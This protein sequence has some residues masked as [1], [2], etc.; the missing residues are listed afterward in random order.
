MSKSRFFIK[1]KKGFTL[2]ELLVVIAIMAVAA[3]IV[4]PNL[5]GAISSTEYR[6][7]ISYCMTADSFV[8]NFVTLLNQ[9][10][11]K[12]PYEESGSYNYYYIKESP[13]GLQLALKYYN[14]DTSYQYYVLPFSA[15]SASSNPASTITAA[16]Q[17][18]KLEDKDTMVVCIVL[19]DD[20]LTYTLRGLWFYE[21]KSQSIACTYK[22]VGRLDTRENKNWV[23][24]A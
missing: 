6:K 7:D 24:L 22:S 20:K 3:T 21:R 8:G 12:I 23:S 18:Q 15:S 16:I 10:E 17:K 19:S 13:S 2:V 4:A 11:S 14:N 9:G 5:T 1:D